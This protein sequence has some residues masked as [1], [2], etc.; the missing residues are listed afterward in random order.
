[1]INLAWQP[2]VQPPELPPG[3]VHLWRFWMAGRAD[4]VGLWGYLN[5]DERRRAEAFYK[6]IHAEQFAAGRGV[7]RA[8]VA[9]YTGQAPRDVVFAE[10]AFGKPALALPPPGGLS[11]NLSH[12]HNLAVAAFARSGQLG[13]DVEWVRTLPDAH[14]IARRQFHAAEAQWLREAPADCQAEVFFHIWTRKEAV[15]K[16]VGAGL[17]VDLQSF[18]VTSVQGTGETYPLALGTNLAVHPWNWHEFA[19]ADGYRACLVSDEP[20]RE[21]QAFEHVAEAASA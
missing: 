15:L 9:G 10:G 16:A 21:L 1:M 11:F 2:A 12:S 13:V 5:A 18:D 7:L 3:V 19:A 6:P 20:V 4:R 17:T 8:L 14:S